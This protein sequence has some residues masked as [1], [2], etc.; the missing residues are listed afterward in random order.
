[1]LDQS[2]ALGFISNPGEFILERNVSISASSCEINCRE[3]HTPSG[4]AWKPI[5]LYSNPIGNEFDDAQGAFSVAYADQT[6][7][8]HAA[9]VEAYQSGCIQALVEDEL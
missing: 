3:M 9:M 4:D 6:E 8:D 7:Q 5:G 2:A 1:M